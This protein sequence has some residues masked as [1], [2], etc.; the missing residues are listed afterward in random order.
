MKNKWGNKII[1]L[2]GFVLSCYPLI[3]H[4]IVQHQ[5]LSVVSSFRDKTNKENIQVREKMLTEAKKYNE[6][7]YEEQ[8]MIYCLETENVTEKYEELLKITNTGIM[9]CIDIPKIKTKLPIYHG[10]EDEILAEGAGHLKWTSLPVGGENTHCVIT[11]HRGLPSSKLFVR[12]DELRKGD[13]FFVETCGNKMVYEVKRIVIIE[14][15][16]VQLLQIKPKQDLVS[17][18]TCTPYG[19]NT[20]RLVVTGERVEGKKEYEKIKAKLPSVRECTFDVLP[21]FFLSIACVLVYG[22]RV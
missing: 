13:I 20:H 18:I 12:L 7:L 16:E 22:E 21:F 5:Q 1:F 4:R 10:T 6:I 8:K 17:L 9:A 11:G 19:I 3:S 2:V 15:Q 14:P